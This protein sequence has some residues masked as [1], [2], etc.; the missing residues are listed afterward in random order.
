[1]AYTTTSTLGDA[2]QT[3][4]DQT[5]YFALRS[6]PLFEMVADVR[7]TNQTHSGSGVQFTFY[8]DMA[9][10]TSALTETSDVTSFVLIFEKYI[11]IC[12]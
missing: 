2:V 10:A 5:A 11:Y 3:A 12:S 7:S 6:Q 1:M 8:A 9:Q 4:F